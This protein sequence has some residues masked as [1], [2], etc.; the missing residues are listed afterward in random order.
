MPE[1]AEIKEQSQQVVSAK[2]QTV[3]H[4]NRST[5]L[6]LIRQH[7]PVSRASLARLA[8]I[9]RSN[10]SIIVEDLQSRGLLREEQSRET[11]KGRTPALISLARGTD[12]VVAVNLRRT[13]T[14]VV[15]ASLD[16]HVDSTYSFTTPD[17]PATFLDEMEGALRSLTAGVT[18]A[19]RDSP[20]VAQVVV[21][22]PGILDT[23][24]RRHSTIWTPGLAGYTGM[25]MTSALEAR[26]KL[27]C[28]LANNAGLGAIAALR[29]AEERG[30]PVK[31]FVFLVVG[32][33]GVGSGVV[34][35]RHL[36][37]GHDAAYAGEVGHTVI[38]PRG[39]L[40]DCGRRGCWQLYICDKAT[41]NRYNKKQEYSASRFEE[42]LRQVKAGSPRALQSLRET[43]SYLSL[44]ISNIALMLNPEKILIAGA[45]TAVWPILQE[46]LKAAFFLP[47]H[48]AMIQ[49]VEL[50]VDQ[51]FLRGAIECG[52]D[53]VVSRSNQRQPSA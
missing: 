20:H 37:S 36:Y 7:Q 41:W 50:P 12:R 46:D 33:V 44:G 15:L 9:H 43:A 19:G 11:R 6:E 51:L 10:I 21:S 17:S 40:C 16:G 23:G 1:S 34:L 45:L 26:L 18:G 35:H 48:H 38:D 49:P 25:D 53:L 24:G 27:P 28:L 4:L 14:T 30:E 2:P 13:R 29:E 39:P 5:V 8:G 31:D 32:D 42:F 47:H 3:R 22:I 52:I